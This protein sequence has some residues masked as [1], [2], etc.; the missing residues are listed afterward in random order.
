MNLS[1][2][3]NRKLLSAGSTLV[4]AGLLALLGL[5][6]FKRP[7]TVMALKKT[8]GIDLSEVLD[9]QVMPK[10]DAPP[11]PYRTFSPGSFALRLKP[12]KLIRNAK[13]SL[14]VQDYRQFES[15]LRDLA[16]QVGYLANA[17]V[18][19]GDHRTT[20]NLTLMAEASH[21]DEALAAVKSL[22]QVKSENLSVEDVSQT[23]TDLEAR[24]AN[25]RVAAARLRE[26]IQTRTGQL[27]DVIEAEQALSQV[28]EELERMEAQKRSLDDRIAF[29]TLQL[30]VVEPPPAAVQPSAWAPLRTAVTESTQSLVSLGIFLV[31]ITIVLSPWVLL[32]AGGWLL[33]RKHQKTASSHVSQV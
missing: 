11:S 32:G 33:W 7:A 23:Y 28:T 6:L 27:S 25:Q 16:L 1:F 15:K 22:G 19:R 5:F 8:S 9:A 26:I 18:S 24:Q 29:S 4:I 10:V 30:E 20:A 21:F 17:Q 14:E 12:L 3:R 13:L 2:F 31:Q